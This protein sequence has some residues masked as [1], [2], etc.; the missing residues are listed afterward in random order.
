MR[1][2]KAGMGPDDFDEIRPPIDRIVKAICKRYRLSRENCEDFGQNVWYELIKDDYAVLRK[3]EGRSSPSTYLTTVIARIYGQYCHSKWRPS[4]E[5]KRLGEKAIHLERLLSRDGHTLDEAIKILTTGDNPR[6]TKAEIERLYWR[7]PIR[8]P[9]VRF[10]PDQDISEPPAPDQ[11]DEAVLR[12][13]RL[14]KARELVKLLDAAIEKLDAEDQVILQ[15]RFWGA[16]TVP[17]IA[18]ALRIEPAKKLYKRLDFLIGR[19]A[20]EMVHAGVSRE[21]ALDILNHHD[22]EGDELDRHGAENG[23]RG[24][25]QEN[26]GDLGEGTTPRGEDDDDDH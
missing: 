13:E 4:A 24:P 2:E 14:K 9:R 10:V 20:D 18:R 17:Q 19:L 26:D 15:M 6:Y 5:A 16:R 21:D 12:E 1:E 11:T 25:S 8:Q 22:V 23:P 3:F 7:L